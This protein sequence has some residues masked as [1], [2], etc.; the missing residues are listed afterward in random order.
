MK[1]RLINPEV[2]ATQ[3]TNENRLQYTHSGEKPK[4]GDFVVT[5]SDGQ[6]EIMSKDNF[7]KKYKPALLNDA[8]REMYRLTT[9]IIDKESL[10][11]DSNAENLLAE[12]CDLARALRKLIQ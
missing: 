10:V 3:I 1:Y 2:F 9:Q 5:L 7:S 6:V 12:A 8:K 11:D 4:V